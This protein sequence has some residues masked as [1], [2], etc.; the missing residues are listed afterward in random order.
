[1][2]SHISSSSTHLW[3]VIKNGFAPHDP[4]LLTGREE[5]DEQLNATA[6][7]LL[8]QAVTDTH[9]AHINNLSTAKEVWDYLT[10]ILV[11]NES[12]RS[13]KFDELKSEERDLIMR[14]NETPD[15]MYQRILALATALTGFG[16]KDN[17]D[18]YI[19]HMF[20][21]SINPREPIRSE[22][23]WS[24]PDFGRMTSDE[25]PCEFT[26]LTILKKNAEETRARVLSGQGVHNIALKAK[27]VYKQEE[28]QE[29]ICEGEYWSPE[30]NKYALNEHLALTTNAF[31]DANKHNIKGSKFK[32]SPRKDGDS[33]VRHCYNCG[34]IK[35]FIAKC[36]YENKE[37]HGGRLIPKSRSSKFSSSKKHG[38]KDD[39][40]KG[41]RLL[42]AQE[43]YDS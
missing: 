20:M 37:D 17:G 11:G 19:K 31:W 10:M 28:V 15:E 24:R 41:E 33:K 25:V 35:H 14:D 8:Q 7:H 34:E 38:N 6:K 36:P 16:C 27:V 23:I 26:A 2:K 12:I 3:R 29:E 13:S 42:V 32:S 1:M 39:K 5:V 22:I 18:D 43:E 9:V 21:T 4:L 40:K 30:D